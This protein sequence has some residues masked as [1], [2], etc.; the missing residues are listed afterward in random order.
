MALS[1]NRGEHDKF[2]LQGTDSAVNNWLNKVKK[3]SGVEM[4]CALDTIYVLGTV[5]A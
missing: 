5:T 4:V 3:I 1:K 2:S